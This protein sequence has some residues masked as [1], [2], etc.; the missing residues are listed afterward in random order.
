MSFANGSVNN[1]AGRNEGSCK[2][3]SFGLVHDL[4]EQAVLSCFGDFYRKDVLQ[5]PDGE[6]HANIRAFME[7][8][9]A[10]IQFECSALTDKSAV[11]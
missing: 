8:G 9:W 3:F 11:F 7:S 5:N 2:I 6:R 4:S 10:G 1:K